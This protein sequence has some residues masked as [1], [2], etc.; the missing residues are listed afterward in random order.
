MHTHFILLQWSS[1][2]LIVTYFYPWA[3]PRS[4]FSNQPRDK[5]VGPGGLLI[6]ISDWIFPHA[7][8]LNGFDK[9]WICI[10]LITLLFTQSILDLPCLAGKDC[11][12]TMGADGEDK[13]T[14]QKASSDEWFMYRKEETWFSIEYT[15]EPAGMLLLFRPFIRVGETLSR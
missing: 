7:Y 3:Y 6:L 5:G 8:L 12:S 1:I 2:Y 4:V 15:T 11:Q 9:I 10:F 13:G 14:H